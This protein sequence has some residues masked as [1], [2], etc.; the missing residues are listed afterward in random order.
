MKGS[1]KNKKV[2]IYREDLLPPS[3]TFIASQG[4]CLS[5][6]QCKFSGKSFKDNRLLD[7]SEALTMDEYIPKALKKFWNIPFKLFGLCPSGFEKELLNFSPSLVHIHFANDA[8]WFM[9]MNKK[10]NVPMVVT[11]H[12][13]DILVKETKG[14]LAYSIYQRRFQELLNYTNTFIAVSEFTKN[15]LIER[16]CH[17][18]KIKVHYIGVDTDKFQ[19]DKEI[20]PEENSVLFVGRLV[21]KKGCKY[22][23]EAISKVQERI[24]NANLTIIGDGPL[25]E[26][27]EQLASEKLKNYKFLGSQPPQEI[28]RHL[29]K[30][31]VFCVPSIVADNGDA[32]TFGIVFIE[33]QAMNVPVVS[34]KT[35]GIPEAV[36]DGTTGLLTEEKDIDGLAS[37]IHKLLSDTNL[38]SRMSKE[39]REYVENNFNLQRQTQKLETIYD[40]IISN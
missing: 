29:N 31:K 21:E 25:R 2:L 24:P 22:L 12:G 23:I 19:R 16:G 5:H 30:T 18:D 11:I 7:K 15:K 35:G 1:Y 33:A 28:K 27:L 8:T 40:E 39:S 10:L 17:K 26:N 14:S 6:Y 13:Y 3:E 36:K 34:F 38:W 32:E 20:L 9:P 37:R 4:K